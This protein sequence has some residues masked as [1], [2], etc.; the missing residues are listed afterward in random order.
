M[1][2]GGV[3]TLTWRFVSERADPA[4]HMRTLSPMGEGIKKDECLLAQLLL[5][6]S[7]ETGCVGICRASKTPFREFGTR[8]LQKLN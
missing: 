4:R 1:L 3:T 8:E 5:A 6:A 2:I 7:F